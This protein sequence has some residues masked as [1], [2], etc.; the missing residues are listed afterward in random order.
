[1]VGVSELIHEKYLGQQLASRKSSKI[2]A[3][4]AVV[5]S[6]GVV[7][8][9]VTVSILPCHHEFH[10]LYHVSHK[11]SNSARWGQQEKS[12]LLM[13][14]ILRIEEDYL[15]NADVTTLYPM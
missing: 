2:V 9:V 6:I 1:M 4:V 14:C 12:H 11:R 8:V 13:D 3:V 10:Y 7:I 5:S 15:L